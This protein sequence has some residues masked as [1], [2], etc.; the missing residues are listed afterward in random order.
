MN[1]TLA[2]QRA[3]LVIIVNCMLL[4]RVF[5]FT[6]TP[7]RLPLLVPISDTLPPCPSRFK[8]CQ[9]FYLPFRVCEHVPRYPA[10]VLG[11][12]VMFTLLEM[13]RLFAPTPFRPHILFCV[14][15]DSDTMVFYG[16]TGLTFSHPCM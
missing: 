5:L 16:N 10:A 12:L 3:V 14:S 6:P 11:V 9:D 15:L 7:L 8:R 1:F 13:V 2:T 4:A